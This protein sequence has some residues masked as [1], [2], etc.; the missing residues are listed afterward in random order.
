MFAKA[1]R[2]CH[3]RHAIKD[4]KITKMT[5]DSDPQ[6][7]A[8]FRL[9]EITREPI[10]LYKILKFE[11]MVNSGGHAKAAIAAGQVL[12]NGQLETQKR[13]KITSGDSIEF[14]DDKIF[15]KLSSSVS[16]D[17]ALAKEEVPQTTAMSPTPPA[18]QER[19]EPKAIKDH[20]A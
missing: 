15:I 6:T 2:I 1:S 13:K 16:V 19:G 12:L 3:E 14:N 11:G 4:L 17:A 9:V 20:K 7:P 5:S 10:E 18:N 8:G